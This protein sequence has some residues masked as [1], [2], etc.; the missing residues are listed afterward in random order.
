MEVHLDSRAEQL[1]ERQLRS[2]LY[3]TAE[4]VVLRALEEL[5]ASM[6]VRREE[7]ERRKAVQ[8]MML[9]ARKHSLT[10]GPL[11]ISDLIHE[12]HKY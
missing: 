2:G 7:D 10:L 5:E 11:T 1:I 12:G 3:G 8:E 6:L 9:F 4:Q